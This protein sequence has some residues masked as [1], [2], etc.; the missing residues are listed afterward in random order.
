[1]EGTQIGTANGK[2]NW[3]GYTVTE[4]FYSSDVTSVGH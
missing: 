1:M 2:D 4:Q 3:A